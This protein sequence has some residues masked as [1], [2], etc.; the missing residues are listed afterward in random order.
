[1]RLVLVS[2]FAMT[3]TVA[4]DDSAGVTKTLDVADVHEAG[5]ELTGDVEQEIDVEIDVAEDVTADTE[6]AA[7]V[8]EDGLVDVS[9]TPSE[10]ADL[11]DQVETD[12]H[13]E[14][15][16]GRNSD[17]PVGTSCVWSWSGGELTLACRVPVGTSPGGA[18]CTDDSDCVSGA[19]IDGLC[20]RPC[21]SAADCPVG[22]ACEDVEVGGYAARSCVPLPVTCQANADCA[23]PQVCVVNRGHGELSLVCGAPVGPGAL[24]ASCTQDAHCASNLCL[25][26]TCVLPCVRNADCSSDGEWVCSN[27]AVPTSGGPVT[28]DLCQPR[29][30]AA[31]TYDGMCASP[32]RCVATKT[33]LQVSFTCGVPNAGG[34]ESGA[35]CSHDDHCAQRLCL[36]GQCAGP[37]QTAVH[38]P[39][40]FECRVAPVPLP[41]GASGQASLCRPPRWCEANGQCLSAE[42]CYAR[43]EPVDVTFFCRGPNATTGLLGAVCQADHDCRGNLC[44]PGRF[45]AY[46]SQ[47]CQ[48]GSDCATGFSCSLSTVSTA[49]GGTVQKRICTEVAP[50][51]CTSQA[52]CAAGTVCAVVPN[53]T[54]GGL[55]TVCMPNQGGFAAG[56]PCSTHSQCAA[57]SCVNGV[58][59]PPCV[60]MGQCA[61]GQICDGQLLQ[62]NGLSGT[63]DVCTR[64]LDQVCTSTADCTDG[65]RVCSELR[66]VNNALV[67]YC[68]FPNASGNPLGQQ[69]GS[70]G[71]CFHDYCLNFTGE[72]TVICD[73][74]QQ[75][76]NGQV[77]SAYGF[78]PGP[79]DIGMCVRSCLDND[80]CNVPGANPGNVCTLNWNYRDDTVDRVCELPTGGGDVGAPCPGQDGTLCATGLCLRTKLFDG[81]TCTSN[82]NC[83]A[84]KSCEYL[85]GMSGARQCATIQDAC[86]ALCDEASDC[87][88]ST[89]SG[90]AL[91]ICSSDVSVTLPS[92]TGTMQIATCSRP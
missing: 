11:M 36:E 42:V 71:Q 76:A 63:F 32:L 41:G 44:V 72:C 55:E 87:T 67:S 49:S 33:D 56:V 65:V 1:M 80:D 26:G 25:S 62:Q 15:P 64:L 54:M 68:A 10:V 37:C 73:L 88:S 51:P 48:S 45:N 24:G 77:C 38:C 35:T 90:N 69:C 47:P 4:C 84:G 86:T 83:D 59:G 74:D 31:C 3:W 27:T 58:C 34:G 52:S 29:P 85:S 21:V 46:C 40:D 70:D 81:V 7:E 9:D 17:C 18:A 2:V 5:E 75:C 53:V 60:N 30:P 39:G 91:T 8:D 78:T 82:A 92:G 79:T 43:R 22:H 19:C 23:A 13:Q 16:C 20:G 89:F 12:V 66:V 50:L 57:R 61:S 14:L 6:I 28:L